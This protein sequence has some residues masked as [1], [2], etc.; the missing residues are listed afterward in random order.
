MKCL[1][2]C[3]IFVFC[4]FRT[5]E[6][7]KIAKDIIQKIGDDILSNIS[8]EH[9]LHGMI[10][11]CN[12]QLHICLETLNRHDEN[13]ILEKELTGLTDVLSKDQSKTKAQVG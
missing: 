3:Y 11:Y 10:H 1:V 2:Y 12:F 6:E 4:L 5:N 13:T 9:E 7:V 8:D